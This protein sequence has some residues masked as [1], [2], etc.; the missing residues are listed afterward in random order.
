MKWNLI[1]IARWIWEIIEYIRRLSS[2][3]SLFMHKFN[4]YDAGEWKCAIRRTKLSIILDITI[5][6]GN[7]G[8]NRKV[9]IK[10]RLVLMSILSTYSRGIY[11]ENLWLH[12]YNGNNNGLKRRQHVISI[13]RANR[14]NRFNEFDRFHRFHG[15]CGYAIFG[16]FGMLYFIAYFTPLNENCN[17]DTNPI[18]TIYR[19]VYDTKLSQPTVL[20]NIFRNAKSN[21]GA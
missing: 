6:I 12:V 21:L 5:D 19:W 20:S 18:P 2:I 7:I 11:L 13:T 1:T 9:S 17:V 3:T 14:L 15:L 8:N 4:N 16:W 10:P